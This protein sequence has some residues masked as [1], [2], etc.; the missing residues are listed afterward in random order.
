MP[1]SA[2]NNMFP[3]G[4]TGKFFKQTAISLTSTGRGYPNSVAKKLLMR[5]RNFRCGGWT[6]S[7][8]SAAVCGSDGRERIGKSPASWIGGGGGSLA[9]NTKGASTCTWTSLGLDGGSAA[10]SGPVASLAGDDS[11]AASETGRVVGSLPDW[12]SDVGGTVAARITAMAGG[13][14]PQP[15]GT[16]VSTL[17][18]RPERNTTCS[19]GLT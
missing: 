9:R 19:F 16:A 14:Q 11:A 3:L 4:S 18:S 13:G 7:A 8:D 15:A 12:L 6:D 1:A 17:L 10:V 5:P 2:Q